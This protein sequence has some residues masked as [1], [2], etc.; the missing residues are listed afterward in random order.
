M[1]NVMKDIS[2]L[3]FHLELN[4][5]LNGVGELV[6]SGVISGSDIIHLE[7]MRNWV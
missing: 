7:S 5:S 6:G 2:A 1:N 3:R 4:P